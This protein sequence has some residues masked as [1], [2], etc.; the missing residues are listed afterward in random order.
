MWVT[1][2]D[3]KIRFPSSAYIARTV[4]TQQRQ[5]ERGNN[6]GL[7]HIKDITGKR[8]AIMVPNGVSKTDAKTINLSKAYLPCYE[9][10]GLDNLQLQALMLK[11]ASDLYE[12]SL[13]EAGDSFSIPFDLIGEH[14]PPHAPC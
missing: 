1:T 3:A 8:A 6:S 14:H 4:Y 13:A 5:P 11:T 12:A 9:F 10:R 7:G 2:G